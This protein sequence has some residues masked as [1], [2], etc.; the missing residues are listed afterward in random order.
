MRFEFKSAGGSVAAALVG[1]A[2]AAVAPAANAFSVSAE[3]FVQIVADDGTA[4]GVVATANEA[5]GTLMQSAVSLDPIDLVANAPTA[6]T[7]TSVRASAQIGQ[8]RLFGTYLSSSDPGGRGT[9]VRANR[10]TVRWNDVATITHDTL[11]AGEL[12]TFR[13]VFNLDGAFTSDSSG[14]A[15]ANGLA[16]GGFSGSHA[17]DSF[18]I[19]FDQMLPEAEPT[20]QVEDLLTVPVGARV[21]LDGSLHFSFGGDAINGGSSTATADFDNTATFNL[22]PLTPGATYMLD[23]GLAFVPVPP[24]MGFLAAG[25]MLLA[26]RERRRRT[27]AG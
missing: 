9:G 23:S 4:T 14:N 20:W 2:F 18:A 8:L 16:R 7:S 11:G 21:V 1:M 6:R 22:V 19:R 13:A 25:A 3:A 12:V 27:A 17:L 15:Q 10:A 24:A 26:A 5:T